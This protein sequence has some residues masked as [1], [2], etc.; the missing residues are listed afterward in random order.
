MLLTNI[1][2]FPKF[3]ENKPCT[4]LTNITMILKQNTNH[5]STQSSYSQYVLPF[6]GFP[7]FPSPPQKEACFPYPLCRY[8]VLWI[9]K[10]TF[11]G[12]AVPIQFVPNVATTEC[13]TIDQRAASPAQ[14]RVRCVIAAWQYKFSDWREIVPTPNGK[15]W[16]LP[17]WA[18]WNM[19]LF[20]GFS[21]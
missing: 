14:S 12:T 13:G 21:E 15:N 18:Y 2:I 7:Q 3:I 9:A 6:P 17:A 10:S 19:I 8:R 4:V 11:P 20:W 16:L 1:R 5:A